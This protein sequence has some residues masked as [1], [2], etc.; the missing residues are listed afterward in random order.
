M[1]KLSTLLVAFAAVFV[2]AAA[3]AQLLDTTLTLGK[4]PDAI[5]VP[6]TIP[7]NGSYRITVT[8]FGTASGPV[9]LARVDAGFARGS[10]LVT[11]ASV[12]A[13]SSTATTTK[14]FTA[15]AGEHRLIIAGQPNPPATVGSAG[16][17]VDDPVSGTVLYETLEVFTVP[18][19]PTA[20]PADFE[21]EIAVTAAG[22][23]TL[24]IT[25]FGLPQPLSLLQ[26]AVVRK[27]NGS[28]VA[29][30][31]GPTEIALNAAGA[32]VYQVFVHA[33][34]A[35]AA[36]RG[37][38]GVNLRD[39]GTSAKVFAQLHELGEWPFK[40]PFDVSAPT[41]LSLAVNDFQFPLPLASLGAVLTHDARLAAP[42]LTG[43]GTTNTPGTASGAFTAYVDAANAGSDAGSFGVTVTNGSSARLVETVESVAPPTAQTDVGAIDEAFDVTAA[44]DYTLT[45]TDFGLAGFFDAFTSVQLALTRDNQVV[46]TLG[47]AGNFV[48]AA[49][50]GHYSI[51]ILADPAGSAG[52]GLLGV[53]VHGG[54]GDP[55]IYEKTAA[56][57]TGFISATVDVPTAQSVDVTLTDLGFPADFDALK[58]AV[59]RGSVRAGEISGG[60]T[61]SFPATPGKYFVNLLATPDAQVGYSTLG[62][63]VRATPSAP[64]VALTASVNSV[65]TGS[66]VALTWSSTD[67]TACS[68]S[69]GWTGSRATSGTTSVGPLNA[70]T[71]FGL[72]CTGLGGSDDATVTVTVTAAQRSSGGGGGVDWLTLAL[73]GLTTLARLRRGASAVPV[74]L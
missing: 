1:A 11:S 43:S 4:R 70:N 44:G 10:T 16:I 34:L 66:N 41:T 29:N 2:A 59:T 18:P 32:E 7:A 39:T 8:D 62:V 67:A 73:L 35:G 48:F 45:L 26:T 30:V 33:E 15:V 50:P 17:K 14:T 25:D 28:L 31:S 74:A 3:H 56:V 23:Y 37:L 6:V 61:F 54:P 63:N 20:S 46:K 40:Y 12:L 13:A 51:A 52:Q 60:G 64:V 42:A 9:R 71:T 49:T 38:V 5:I 69:G 19:P 53:T 68:A 58:V 24:Q 47:A 27:S 36:P 22:S 57:G 55:T 72:S 21:H 65:Q